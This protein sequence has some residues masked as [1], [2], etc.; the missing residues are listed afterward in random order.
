M[1]SDRR[2]G[3]DGD[4]PLRAGGSDGLRLLALCSA[5]GGVA[6]LVERL[7]G[8][9]EVRGFKSHRLHQNSLVR[10]VKFPAIR[11]LPDLSP[12]FPAGNEF[13]RVRSSSIGLT[14]SSIGVERARCVVADRLRSCEVH[15][16][17]DNMQVARIAVRVRAKEGRSRGRVPTLLRRPVP[18]SWPAGASGSPASQR[19]Q[20]SAQTRQRS[21]IWA[22]RSH[23]SPQLLQ[24]ATHAS[25]SGVMTLP[26]YSVWRLVTPTAATQMSVQSRH[27]RTHLTISVTFR[28]LKSAAAA[29]LGAV[30]ERVDSDSQHPGVDGESAWV[31]VQQ[32]LSEAHGPLL[33]LKTMK[34]I[35]CVTAKACGWPAESIDDA[36]ATDT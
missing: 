10:R 2:E 24:M 30:V 18:I 6:Q 36:T 25:K 32:P 14:T 16:V 8:S 20:A 35:S 1:T 19:R 26:S 11:Q 3:V 31:G 29:G 13:D 5:A 12:R 9:Q 34:E 28:S 17:G 7:T 4:A 21:C 23:S 33:L 15:L 27:S 22:W